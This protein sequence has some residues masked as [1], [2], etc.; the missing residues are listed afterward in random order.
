M[1]GDR[2]LIAQA[3]EEGLR[4]RTSVHGVTRTTTRDVVFGG[5][6]IPAGGDLYVHYAAAQRDHAVF[7]DPDV[8]DIGRPNVKHHF[9]FGKWT[10]IASAP[11]WRGSRLAWRWSAS[12]TDPEHASRGGQPETV[13][14]AHAHAGARLALDRVCAVRAIEQRGFGGVEVLA[15]ARSR[16]GPV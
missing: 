8:F 15:L 11:L 7:A 6:E 9:A 2:E 5:V 13:V 1:R 3:V 14:P 10:H 16:T 4:Y 12:P